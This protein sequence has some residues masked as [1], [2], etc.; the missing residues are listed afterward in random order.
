MDFQFTVWSRD[1]W[2][3]L[4]KMPAEYSPVAGAEAEKGPLTQIDIYAG[5]AIRM[6]D[7]RLPEGIDV[8]DNRLEAH[9]F[10]LADGVVYEGKVI[11]LATQKPLA[12][13]VEIELIA[14]RKSGGY[15]HSLV[16]N[17]KADKKGRYVF[18]NVPAGWHRIIAKADG[19]VPRIIGH[20]RS[21][22][23][24]RHHWFDSGLSRPTV[25]AG[26]VK[27]AEGEGLPDATVR[28]SGLTYDKSNRYQTPHTFTTTTDETGAF[29][30]ENVPLGTGSI[31]ASKVGYVRPGLSPK[32]S[33]PISDLEIEMM[34]SAFVRV[35][36]DFKQKERPKNY[37]VNIE[38]EG[39]S[40]VGSWGGSGK[41]DEN[42][43]RIF[44]NVPPGRY[45]IHGHPNPSRQAQH[46]EKVTV[47]LK[48]GKTKKV[49]LIAK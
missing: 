22:D 48:G 3:R 35:T 7:V 11:Q 19:F 16:A 44:K 29:H 10:T 18:K 31:R 13:D 40:V 30:F 38:P 42:N 33:T 27:D 23:V 2:E 6:Q 37:I 49:T 17:V 32:V 28:L 45:V 41:I 25:V 12:A 24:P 9:G 1:N 46:T 21:D 4:R 26:Q 5:G 39:G 20:V 43:E 36:V 47:E 14:P 8:V 34:K 15:D